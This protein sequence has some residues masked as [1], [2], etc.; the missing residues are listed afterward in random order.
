MLRQA[1]LAAGLGLSMAAGGMIGLALFGPTTTHGPEEA[2][3]QTVRAI[4]IGT[5]AGGATWK[6][7]E[8]QLISRHK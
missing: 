8:W 1:A 6:I 5:I 3:W 7:A 4:V 2:I